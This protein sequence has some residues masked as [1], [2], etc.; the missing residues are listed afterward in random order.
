M[1]VERAAIPPHPPPPSPP[2]P[3]PHTPFPSSL[4]LPPSPSLRSPK[5]RISFTFPSSTTRATPSLDSLERT[6]LPHFTI[7]IA[8]KR[9]NK[10]RRRNGGEREERMRM[11][12]RDE[13]VRWRSEEEGE[14]RGKVGGILSSLSLVKSL[15]IHTFFIFHF[16]FLFFSFLLSIVP[17]NAPNRKWI[18]PYF[19]EFHPLTDNFLL[20]STWRFRRVVPFATALPSSFSSLVFHRSCYRYRNARRILIVRNKAQKSGLWYNFTRRESIERIGDNVQLHRWFSGH[21]LL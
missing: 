10:R 7:N 3:P 8:I 1:E 4:F 11:R 17:V 15:I 9:D 6:S 18:P 20:A 13:G 14:G 16:S 5:G 2:P 21:F 19:S 12:R